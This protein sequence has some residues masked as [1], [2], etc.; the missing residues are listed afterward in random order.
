MKE[1]SQEVPVLEQLLSKFRPL[2]L[3]E[4]AL[5][6]D[7]YVKKH[8]REMYEEAARYVKEVLVN[9]KGLR[10]HDIS[11]LI[12]CSR[13][14]LSRFVRGDYENTSWLTEKILKF[15]ERLERTAPVRNSQM[16]MEMQRTQA[17]RDKKMFTENTKPLSERMYTAEL[18]T[19]RPLSDESAASL[20]SRLQDAIE[21]MYGE[22]RTMLIIESDEMDNNFNQEVPVLGQLTLKGIRLSELLEK[23]KEVNCVSIVQAERVFNTFI[24]KEKKEL[25][26]YRQS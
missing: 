6:F 8:Y 16:H 11:K 20:K 15:K 1:V 3:E 10:I 4:L 2:A 21:G 26:K 14:A 17:Q 18:M 19:G 25:K 13:S 24:L 9:E 7:A 5:Q 12:G 23:W 22:D